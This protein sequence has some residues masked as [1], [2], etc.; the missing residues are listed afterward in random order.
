MNLVSFI[1][2]GKVYEL[3]KSEAATIGCAHF[4]AATKSKSMCT[5]SYFTLN[6]F[7]TAQAKSKGAGTEAGVMDLR[8][9]NIFP[10]LMRPRR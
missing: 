6:L 4:Y 3:A 2:T 10:G 1:W 7:S 5:N 9:Q 8:Y